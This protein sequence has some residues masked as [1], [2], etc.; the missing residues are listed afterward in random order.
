MYCFYIKCSFLKLWV[1]VPINRK[2]STFLMMFY[3]VDLMKNT[4]WSCFYCFSLI[5]VFYYEIIIHSYWSPPLP[6]L[7]CRYDYFLMAI[8]AVISKHLKIIF[9]FLEGILIY[10]TSQESPLS[11]SVCPIILLVDARFCARN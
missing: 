2:P 9:I 7:F 1:I 6:P 11:I 10:L 8:L 5:K 4:I 3:R